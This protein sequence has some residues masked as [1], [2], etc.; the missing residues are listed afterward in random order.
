MTKALK[1]LMLCV[2]LTA[3]MGPITGAAWADAASWR[4]GA[5]DA[6]DKT[7]TTWGAPNCAA[8]QTTVAKSF[9]TTFSFSAEGMG[10]EPTTGFPAPHFQCGR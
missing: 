3:T 1:K 9:G 4:K 8:A 7:G 5:F 6:L 2:A 10:I